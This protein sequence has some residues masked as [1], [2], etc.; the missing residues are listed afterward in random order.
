MKFGGP[1]INLKPRPPSLCVFAVLKI[2]IEIFLFKLLF[3][4]GKWDEELAMQAGVVRI[5]PSILL[6]VWGRRVMYSHDS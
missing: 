6:T 2:L 5:H 3:E 1:S 4:H